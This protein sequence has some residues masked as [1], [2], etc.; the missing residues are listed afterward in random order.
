MVATLALAFAAGAPAGATE[1]AVSRTVEF[2]FRPAPHLQLAM[3]IERPDGTFLATV[4]LTQSVSYR[5]IGN[6]PGASQMNSGYRWPYGR[7]EAV[8]PVWAHRRAAAPGAVGFTRVIFQERRE[9]WASR[10]REDSSPDNYFCLSFLEKTNANQTSTREKALDAITCPSGFASDKG[11]YMVAADLA[12]GYSE[13]TQVAGANVPRPLDLVSLYPPRRDYKHCTGGPICHDV[14]DV[15]S[16]NDSALAVMPELDA[17]T[18]ATPPAGTEQTV[19]FRVPDEWPGGDYVAFVE[20]NLEGDYNGTFNDIT[21]PTPARGDDIW[22]SWA[23]DYGYPYRGQPS[24]VYAIPFTIEAMGSAG[25]VSFQT[26][27]P[28]GYGDV[29][30]FGP[31]GGALYPM[32]DGRISDDPVTTPGSG[33]DRLLADHDTRQRLTVDVRN[34]PM[35]PAPLVPSQST[36]EAD[37]DTHHSH[38]WGVLH[39]VEPSSDQPVVRYEIRFSEQPITPGDLDSFM[40]AQPAVSADQDQTALQV[41][42]TSPGQPIEVQFGGMSPLRHYYVGIR[43]VDR[44][45]TPG[46]FAVAELDTTRI[47]FTKLS[48]CFIATAAYGSAMEPQV[49][50]LRAVRDALRPRSAIFATAT[51]LYYRSGPVA[52]QLVAK[53]ETAR[54]LARILLGPPAAVAAALS[55]AIGAAQRPATAR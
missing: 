33:A 54:A 39:F 55:P 30:G 46:P 27:A 32:D 1:S 11:R 36:A 13:P 15:D 43:A 2:R 31:K 35:H 17:V 51:D 37:P 38:E 24:V 19:M 4:G 20:A 47:N 23:H 25:V 29:D 5:G 7:R 41:P 12:A 48:G 53:S 28:I 34:C 49:E 42:A 10:W 21:Y 50:A 40:H 22:D 8:L 52:A 18:M 9:G 6:R 26:A 45:G 3:W 16:Y 14:F 44:C